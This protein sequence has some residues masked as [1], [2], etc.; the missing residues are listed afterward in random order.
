MKWNA[1]ELV[2]FCGQD[3]A[4]AS[5]FAFSGAPWRGCFSVCVQLSKSALSDMFACC[6]AFSGVPFVSCSRFGSACTRDLLSKG[7]YSKGISVPRDIVLLQYSAFLTRLA[8]HGREGLW[9]TL[10]SVCF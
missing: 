6:F 9:K 10:R 1:K 3:V 7:L 5:S 4:K 8:C 2:L